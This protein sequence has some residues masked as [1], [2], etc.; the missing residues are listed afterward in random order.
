LKPTTVLSL[1]YAKVTLIISFRLSGVK[2]EKL[3]VP[4]LGSDPHPN[5]SRNY[6]LR[7]FAGV[8]KIAWSRTRQQIMP[9]KLR[10]KLKQRQKSKAGGKNTYLKKSFFHAQLFITASGHRPRNKTG[11]C[12]NC[13]G[14]YLSY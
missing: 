12:H 2:K 4:I 7:G 8:N 14:S 11:T 3:Y 6:Q 9:Q 5:V 1:L 13:I 10:R